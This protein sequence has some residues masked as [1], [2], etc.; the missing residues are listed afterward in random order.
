[1][2]RHHIRPHLHNTIKAFE[3]INHRLLRNTTAIPGQRKSDTFKGKCLAP[4][5]KEASRHHEI[6]E[7]VWHQDYRVRVNGP[8][9]A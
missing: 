3:R 9:P 5:H 6:R 4:T 8:A 1:M 7:A 2:I